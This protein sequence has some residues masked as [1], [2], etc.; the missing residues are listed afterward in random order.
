MSEQLIVYSR[1]GC[2][3]CDDL[4]AG[5]EELQVELGFTFRIKN[6]DAD[7]EL[8][9]RYGTL[10]PVVLAGDIQLCQSFLDVE[11]LKEYFLYNDGLS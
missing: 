2:H 4:I 10:I 9:E 1:A 11:R 8:V 5:L 3:L 7:P 6:I